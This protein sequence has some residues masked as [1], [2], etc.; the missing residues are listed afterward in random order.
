MH[1]SEF[2]RQSV[3]RSLDRVSYQISDEVIDNYWPS[4]LTEENVLHVIEELGT[5]MHEFYKD[6]VPLHLQTSGS[7]NWIAAIKVDAYK[8][9]AELEAAKKLF[10]TLKHIACLMTYS[11]IYE[12]ATAQEASKDNYMADEDIF[13]KHVAPTGINSTKVLDELSEKYKA[14]RNKTVSA[15]FGFIVR[16]YA[17]EY[18]D[19][20]GV[21]WFDDIIA[22]LH[23][24]FQDGYIAIDRKFNK[25]KK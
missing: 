14:D 9:P 20:E 19:G 22:S 21:T 23:K 6:K 2:M 3:E 13:R 7:A 15:Q 24:F 10:E 12:K 16:S 1:F 25:D 8:N 18:S 5:A 4:A 11:K 17:D